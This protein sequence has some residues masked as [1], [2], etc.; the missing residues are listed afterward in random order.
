MSLVFLRPAAHALFATC[1]ACPPLAEIVL[2]SRKVSV[3]GQL[4]T[5]ASS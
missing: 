1:T 4:V 2:K 5:V 3:G